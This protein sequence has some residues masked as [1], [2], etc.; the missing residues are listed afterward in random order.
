MEFLI[1]ASSELTLL[2]HTR[3]HGVCKIVKENGEEITDEDY[4]IVNLF[5][6][7]LFSQI[8]L[9]IG[10]INLAYQDN[11][12]PYK[13]YMETLLTYGFD[14]KYSHL[15]TSHFSKDTPKHFDDLV[16]G[17]KGY[18]KRKEYVKNGELFD[19]CI[20]LHVDFLHT[21]RAI[22][23]GIQ[24]KM[25]LTRSKDAFSILSG[26]GEQFSIKIESLTLFVY[27]MQAS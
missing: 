5:P 26:D 20:P 10:G 15:S 12:Y 13:S 18:L 2:S 24:M 11:L 16:G 7:S 9:E 23:P 1:P 6:Q 21:P 8:D 17:N 3:L 14:S 4:S 27:R 19:F 25:K 22:P